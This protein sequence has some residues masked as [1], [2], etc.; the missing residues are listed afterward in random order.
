MSAVSV[1]GVAKAFGDV[2]ALDQVDLEVAD[3]E[4]VVLLGPSGCGKTTLLRAI[5]GLE[6]LD[7]GTI[8]LGDRVVS[9]PGVHVTP[10]QRQVGLVFQDGAL[11]PHLEVAANVGFGLPRGRRKRDPR[12]DELLDLVGLGGL[13]GRRPDELSGG[14]RQR[15]AIARALAPEPQV[16]L[17]DE[18]FSNLDAAL[19][20]RLREEVRRVVGELGVTAVFVTHDQSEAFGLGD[21]IAIMRDGRLLQVG[22]PADVYRVPVDPWVAGFVG[23][24]GLV[25]ATSD[26]T[27]ATGTFGQVSL[28]PGAPS[29]SVVVLVRPEQ[30]GVVAGAGADFHVVRQVEFRGTTTTLE[31]DLRGDASLTACLL[32]RSTLGVGDPVDV[33]VD[34]PCVAFVA[35]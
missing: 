22:T 23:E 19:R 25:P 11:F 18:P 5:A 34:G 16:L 9:G 24:G 27:T 14:Q 2:C 28:V 7:R 6:T 15:V 4:L 8:E 1:R 29:G 26:G 13:G 20:V 12:I 33:R 32:G 21:R 35:D 30:V 10:E 17:L 31:I 3:G